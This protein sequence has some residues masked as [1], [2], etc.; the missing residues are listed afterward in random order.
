MGK[1]PT[2]K[3]RRWGIPEAATFGVH[4][5]TVP[6]EASFPRVRFQGLT[7][8]ATLKYVLDKSGYMP[9]ALRDSI[10]Q[11]FPPGEEPVLPQGNDQC[12][13]VLS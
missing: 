4:L 3:L 12:S 1:S 6:S 13:Q 10:D 11:P 7:L 5:G 8:E 9:R 2:P